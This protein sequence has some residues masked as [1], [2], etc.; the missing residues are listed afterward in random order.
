MAG[1]LYPEEAATENPL[2]A[3]Q[4]Q[5]YRRANN[6]PQLDSPQQALELGAGLMGPVPILGDLMGLAADGQYK[7]VSK[8]VKAKDIYTNGDSIH[9][10]GFDPSK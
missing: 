4:V 9:E 7:I 10:W 8:K 1:I 3:R 5:N 2:F 6:R